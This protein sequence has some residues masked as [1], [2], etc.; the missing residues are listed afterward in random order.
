MNRVGIDAGVKRAAAG[1][2]AERVAAGPIDD[3]V[4]GPAAYNQA[5]GPLL[6]NVLSLPKGSSYTTPA[7]NWWRI[8]K[9]DGPGPG[10]GYGILREQQAGAGA[11]GIVGDIVDALAEGVVGLEHEPLAK[12]FSET[13]SAL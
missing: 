3:G 12:R 2:H 1:I 4:C 10:G 11:V 8:S 7:R 13:W 9:S 6:T 5:R